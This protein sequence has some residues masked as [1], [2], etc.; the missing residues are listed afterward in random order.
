MDKAPNAWEILQG[1]WRTWKHGCKLEHL[2]E[3]LLFNETKRVF[4]QVF[5]CHFGISDGSFPWG[6]WRISSAD[7]FP[8]W[9]PIFGICRSRWMCETAD[10]WWHD[11]FI[12]VHMLY[13]NQIC[14]IS[15]KWHI[16]LCVYTGWWFEPLWKILVS[17]DDY[18]QY[19]EN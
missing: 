19:M 8:R 16:R 14:N 13:I 17:W 12:Y 9:R 11:R 3:P 5:L 2:Q 18:S 10:G 4:L 1:T 6:L 7:L 15:I